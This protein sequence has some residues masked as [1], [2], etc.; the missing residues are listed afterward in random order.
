MTFFQKSLRITGLFVAGIGSIIA[1]IQI[2][3]LLLQQDTICFNDGCAIV[4]SF[5]K[6]SPVFF[7]LA[8]LVFFQVIFWTLYR[9]DF[10]SSFWSLFVK[11][12][13]LGGIAAEGVLVGYQNFVAHAFCSYCLIILSLIVVLN[14][15]QGFKHILTAI[16]VFLA[17]QIG[18]ASLQFTTP[19]GEQEFILNKGIMTTIDGENK[20][21]KFYLFFSS[22]C[23][24]CEEVIQSLKESPVHP[25]S[26]NP[27]DQV[28]KLNIPFGY[29]STPYDY[30]INISFL[31]NFGITE[32]PVLLVEDG[33]DFL[34]IRGKN[35]IINTIKENCYPAEATIEGSSPADFSLEQII[36]T[37][38]ED[39]EHCS[40]NKDC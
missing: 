24:H 25:V 5:T 26:F 35:Q 10:K 19:A 4:E 15:L 3:L 38:P 31:A 23:P 6:V 34:L 37:K 20:D 12:L 7:N 39:D 11:L 36:P 9:T 2:I 13:L 22:T 14:L 27:V 28:E 32:I 18:F 1:L 33:D 21:K 30:N 29:Q 17:V 8:G 16:A 40:I